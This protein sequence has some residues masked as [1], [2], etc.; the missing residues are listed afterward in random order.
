MRADFKLFCESLS[1][2]KANM[3]VEGVKLK[4]YQE[5]KKITQSFKGGGGVNFIIVARLRKKAYR[6]NR[7]AIKS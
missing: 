4:V 1:L 5:R 3:Y 2:F 6:E 7:K